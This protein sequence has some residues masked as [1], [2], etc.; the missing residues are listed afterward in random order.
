MRIPHAL[1][2]GPD[3]YRVRWGS[4]KD[5]DWQNRRAK[6]GVGGEVGR[7]HYRK[8]LI[9]LHPCQRSTPVEALSTL[10]HEVYHGIDRDAVKRGYWYRND[11]G[12]ITPWKPIRHGTIYALE[13]PW[14]RFLIDNG[15]SF[16]CVCGP[17]NKPKPATSGNKPKKRKSNGKGR[18]SS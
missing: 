12:R 2:I 6:P 13:G 11:R 14:S 7:I 15:V 1:R 3:V 10:I 4:S 18:S 9:T 17:C 16:K 8:K 5:K